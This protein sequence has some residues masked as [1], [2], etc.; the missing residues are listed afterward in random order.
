[1]KMLYCL[2]SMNKGGAERVI[3]NLCNDFIN[4]HDITIVVTKAGNPMYELNKRI[5]YYTLDTTNKK[6][7]LVSRTCKRL[8]R[9]YKIIK[10]EKPDIIISFLP[11]PTYRVML[12][13]KIL[14]KKV[15]IS[16]RNDPNREYNSFVKKYLMKILYR[17]ADG[18]VFQ[19]PDAQKWFSSKIVRDSIVIPNPINNRFICTPYEG[20]RE[21]SI[22]TVG[23]LTSQKNQILLIKAY[24][25]VQKKH[26]E[27]SLKIYGTGELKDYLQDYINEKGLQDKVFLKGNCDDIKSEIYKAGMFVLSSDY[28]GMPNSLMEAMA[29]GLP[30]I[31]TDCKI[32]GPKYL[33]QDGINGLLCEVGNKKQLVDC[34][35]KI[36]EKRIKENIGKNASESC[37]KYNSKRIN[38][39]W[40]NY[41]KKIID[42]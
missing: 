36:I 3:S 33:I 8:K 37:K 31:A 28:E 5:N 40:L 9:L 15:I 26:P 20:K 18:F 4:K 19:T 6:Y 13:N 7:N 35:N 29:L 25:E 41:M 23:R 16:V 11:E 38:Q 14:K 17:D 22:V 24:E 1:M 32:G 39:M 27:Y 34:I 42:K 12:V 21:K 2:G 30:C 10:F